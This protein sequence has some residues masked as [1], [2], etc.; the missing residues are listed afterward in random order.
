MRNGKFLCGILAI[1]TALCLYPVEATDVGDLRPVQVLVATLEG[2]DV[3]LDGG[4]G[5]VGRGK[6]WRLAMTDLEAS[7]AGTP[8]F[9]TT[10]AVVLGD[11]S[12]VAGLLEETRLRPAANLYYGGGDPQSLAAYLSDNS[13]EI[14]ILDLKKREIAG[15]YVRIPTITKT[16]G[17]YQ[18]G[19]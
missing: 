13:G 18:I 7:A 10:C 4:D 6:T 17:G 12:L 15:G 5:M 19:G 3:V 16:E 1:L 11:S 9:G 14:T 8:F 2:G